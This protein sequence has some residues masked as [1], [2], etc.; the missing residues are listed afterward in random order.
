MHT[1]HKL[2]TAAA[3]FICGIASSQSIVG[4]GKPVDPYHFSSKKSNNFL[5]GAVVCG[6]PLAAKV[7]NAIL[8][9]GGN[10]IDAVIATQ[11]ALAVVYPGAG[12]LFQQ[13]QWGKQG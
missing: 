12:R 5:H 11:L 2:I 13:G 7:G 10:A 8:Q 4:V 3:L 6:H 1:K 9:R